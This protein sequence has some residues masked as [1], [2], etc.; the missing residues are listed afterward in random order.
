M[1]V[2]YAIPNTIES[3]LVRLQMSCMHHRDLLFGSIY[4][5]FSNEDNLSKAVFLEHLCQYIQDNKLNAVRT[6]VAKDFIG[7][8]Y[9]FR[10]F[11]IKLFL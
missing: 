9:K 2:Y 8:A 5:T 4:D 1:Y 11:S 3:L 10:S 6:V 7:R